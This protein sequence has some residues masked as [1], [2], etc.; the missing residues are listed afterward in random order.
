MSDVSSGVETRVHAVRR[1][2]SSE[3]GAPGAGPEPFYASGRVFASSAWAAFFS[4]L[5]SVCF[6]DAKD[7][8]EKCL[9]AKAEKRPT[10]DQVLRHR[11]TCE[12]RFPVFDKVLS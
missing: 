8:I 5:R 10:L 12:G 7:L 9:S 1:T 11:W 6:A 3:V 2:E 4:V